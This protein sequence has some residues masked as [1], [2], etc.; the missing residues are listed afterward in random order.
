[1][2]YRYYDTEGNDVTARH[3]TV[4]KEWRK[5]HRLAN[6]DIANNETKKRLRKLAIAASNFIRKEVN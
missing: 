6:T 3:E 2:K 1:M 5:K 4:K